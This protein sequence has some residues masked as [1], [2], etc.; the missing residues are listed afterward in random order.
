MAGDNQ[1]RANQAGE[2]GIRISN[3]ELYDMM[4]Q[5]RDRTAALENRLDNVLGENV[6]LRKRVRGLELRFYGI[7]AGLLAALL[8]LAKVGLPVTA[9]MR[10]I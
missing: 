5:V 10:G 7:A 9:I 2:G 8:I 3:R 1:E 6:D 4:V